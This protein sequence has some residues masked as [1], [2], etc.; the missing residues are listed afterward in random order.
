MRLK[1]LTLKGFKSFADKTEFDFDYGLTGIIGPNGCGK[2]NVVDAVKWVLGSQRP[3]SMR[4]KDMLDVVFSGAEGRQAS[5]C[6]EVH[7]VLERNAEEMTKGEEPGEGE[8]SPA[9]PGTRIQDFESAEIHLGRRLFRSGESE[10]LLNGQVCRLKDLREA[11]MDTG[12]GV[13]AYAVMEQGRIDAV[14]SANPEE[15]RRIFDEAAGIS[16]YKLRRKEAIRRLDRTEQNLARV[17]DLRE[18]KARRVRSLKI[19]ATKARNWK[20]VAERL[21]TIR[22]ALACHSVSKLRAELEGL[23]E[24]MREIEARYEQSQ[25]ARDAARDEVLGGEESLG[26]LRSLVSELQALASE[27]QAEERSRREAIENAEQRKA[28]VAL[29]LE[30]AAEEGG[31]S[32][33]ELA[34][35]EA[36]EAEIAAQIERKRGELAELKEELGLRQ[37]EAKEDQR[38]FR[39]MGK[40]LDFARQAQFALMQERTR[41]QNLIRDEELRLGSLQGKRQRLRAE[42]EEAEALLAERG[43]EEREEAKVQQDLE[44]RL[45]RV[46]KALREHDEEVERLTRDREGLGEELRL[47]SEAGTRCESELRLLQDF[48]NSHAGFDEAARELMEDG[49]GLVG[50]LVEFIRCPRKLG[51][52][53]EAA[54]GPCVQALLVSDRERIDQAL[55]ALGRREGGGRLVLIEGKGLDLHATGGEGSDDAAQ[56]LVRLEAELEGLEFPQE[57]VALLRFCEFDPCLRK[58][59]EAR[60]A[61]FYLVPDLAAARRAAEAAGP[62]SGHAWVTLGGEVLDQGWAFGGKAEAA[63]GLVQRRAAIAELENEKRR[64]DAQREACR[65][66]LAGLDQFLVERMERRERL[67][68]LQE[69][70]SRR[71]HALAHKLEL[72]QRSQ[73][74]TQRRIQD[75]ALELRALEED[76]LE[77]L[78]ALCRPLMDSFLL[79]R[80]EKEARVQQEELVRELRSLEA[81]VQKS[82]ETLS[83]IQTRQA[84]AEAEFRGLEE[85]HRLLGVHREQTRNRI[86]LLV[87]REEELR[88]EG[89]S[90]EER[91]RVLRASRVDFACRGGFVRERLA[92]TT[93]ELE[94]RNAVIER[95]RRLLGELEK[96]ADQD[97]E[98]REE[99]RMR[100]RE[101]EL[102]IQ[103][104]DRDARE[105]LG[106]ELARLLGEVQGYGLWVPEPLYG[107]SVPPDL[108]A[109]EAIQEASLAG[110]MIPPDFFDRE[111][112]LQ[113]LWEEEDFDPEE[114]EREVEILKN[115]LGRMGSVNLGAEEELEHAL[116]EYETLE[117]DCQDLEEARRSLMETIRNLNEESRKLFD[118]TFAEARKNFQE[119]FRM[120]FQGGKA[121]MK[122]VESDDPLESGID[123]FAKPPGKELQSIRLLSGGERSLTALAILFALF[124]VKPSPFCILDEVDAA[125]DEANVERFLR[126]LHLFTKQTQFLVVTHHKR[127]M[128]DCKML[129]GVTMQ[130]KGISSLMS[131]NLEDVQEKDGEVELHERS[132]PP[133]RKRIAGEERVGYQFESE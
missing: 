84:S 110:P 53:L 40:E 78:A 127:T 107:P 8:E 28:E 120:L 17:K 116:E 72:L 99:L 88:E 55:T 32:R 66:R 69:A 13:G 58:L 93:R 46:Q 20:G 31:S 91:L 111:R 60:L 25:G 128:A 63:A 71:I 43:C 89:R 100:L 81:K 131:V 82:Q 96:K 3:T 106:V 4:G 14:L 1:Q 22:V 19:Q 92:S 36:D 80:R 47:L 15:R 118:E 74:E 108:P 114:A 52:A 30:K 11:L 12:L 64:L 85:R 133:E 44:Q 90:L 83:G 39:S 51:A 73:A 54:L 49:E 119:I 7:L 6:A 26:S 67:R 18:E 105:N 86:N 23:R 94:E 34:R 2:S 33:E 38:A 27:L 50:R 9:I 42:L 123:I 125:L 56:A 112:H 61:R 65:E 76:R 59:L 130:R 124:K 77:S 16:R 79:E 24:Q 57:G 97:R 101:K 115:R 117:R 129:Y 29:A 95:S 48:E 121:D 10:Y 5:G 103:G 126:V 45:E 122:L 68:Y 87:Q 37:A 109:F 113:R 35:L 70:I 21:R 75:R 132:A 98:E 104:L 41:A 102:E 62:E